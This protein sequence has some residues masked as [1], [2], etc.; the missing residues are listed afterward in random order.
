MP[1]APQLD[2]AK[3]DTYYKHA[4]DNSGKD[5]FYTFLYRYVDTVVTDDQLFAG[6]MRFWLESL[7]ADFQKDKGKLEQFMEKATAFS[8]KPNLYQITDFFVSMFGLIDKTKI[9]ETKPYYCWYQLYNIFYG[10][11]ASSINADI[12]KKI[13]NLDFKSKEA[14]ELLAD[15]PITDKDIAELKSLDFDKLAEAIEL[16]TQSVVPIKTKLSRDDYVSCLMI[17]HTDFINWLSKNTSLLSVESEVKQIHT[18]KESRKLNEYEAELT[19]PVLATPA[20]I[21]NGYEYFLAP[22]TE[23]KDPWK[24]VIYCLEEKPG[25]EVAVSTLRDN[26]DVRAD[27][28]IAEAL[29][30]SPH[31]NLESGALLP[32]IYEV[33][34]K[35]IT[36][37]P[38]VRISEKELLTLKSASKRER[39]ISK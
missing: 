12:I 8:N 9:K 18:A 20:V 2:T 37:K 28:G 35:T 38:K 36:L 14:K 13:G 21:C 19:F 15:I 27:K 33:S 4:L 11:R 22:M 26:A 10:L 24:I 16:E 5:Q 29:R 7:A 17:F 32:F 31:F 39:R 25:A 34:S 23:R 1:T 3:L 6:A 30:K